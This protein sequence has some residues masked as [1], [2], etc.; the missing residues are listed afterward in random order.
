[1]NDKKPENS[2][3][4]PALAYETLLVEREG[5]VE[6]LTLNRPEKLN[7]LTPLMC[8]EL[9]DY[10]GKLYTDNEVR[11][12]IMRGAGKAFCAG[13]DLNEVKGFTG[14]PAVALTEQRYI[15]EAIMRMRRC[16]QPIIALLD[17]A[18]TGGGFAIALAADVRYA[19]EKTRMNVAMVKLGVTGCDM[20]IS[21]F[22]PRLVGPSV[23]AELMMTGRF[24]DVNR[25]LGLGL[26]S[27]IVASNALETTGRQLAQDMLKTSTLALK[28]TKEGLNA[29]VDAS[30]LEQVVALEDRGQIICTSSGLFEKGAA[31][32]LANKK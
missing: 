19:T 10:F 7:A 27:E 2:R 13:Y 24:V 20:G 1:M 18:A 30:S 8:R 9:R 25:A 31:S 15:S 12:V 32:F 17:G 5:C 22:L 11:V 21:Y 23:A 6:W 14:E 4:E 3:N 29:A 28:L 16:P 26:V